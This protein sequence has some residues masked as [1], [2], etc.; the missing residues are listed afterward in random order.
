LSTAVVCVE[1]EG[2][3]SKIVDSQEVMEQRDDAVATLPYIEPLIQ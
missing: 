2:D 1:E 3:L